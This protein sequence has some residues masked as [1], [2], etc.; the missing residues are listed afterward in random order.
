VLWRSALGVVLVSAGLALSQ[1]SGPLAGQ[2]ARGPE[3]QDQQ[4][5]LTARDT[6]SAPFVVAPSVRFEKADPPGPSRT[7]EPETEDGLAEASPGVGAPVQLS[8]PALGISAPIVGIPASDGVLVPPGDPQTLGWWNGGARPGAA[9]GGA[10]IT[11]HTVSTGGGAF[12]DLEHLRSGDR[13]SVRTD[14][15]VIQYEV[16]GVSIYRKASLAED[17]AEVFSQSVPGRLVLVTCEDWN[18]EIYLSNAVVF[19]EPVAG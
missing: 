16:T 6:T 14:N 9:Q 1:T 18:G 10:L 12:D 2:P 8:I 3:V 15:G 7:L 17:A 11:G 4:A 19:A 5:Q 13:L